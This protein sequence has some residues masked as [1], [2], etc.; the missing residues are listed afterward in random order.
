MHVKL[1]WEYFLIGIKQ[2]IVFLCRYVVHIDWLHGLSVGGANIPWF[3]SFWLVGLKGFIQA[4]FWKV[5]EYHSGKLRKMNI[6]CVFQYRIRIFIFFY[7][8]TFANMIRYIQIILRKKLFYINYQK[9]IDVLYFFSFIQFKCKEIREKL[10][11][12]DK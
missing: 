2:E 9:L 12:L 1:K 6:D 5:I 4:K 7:F 10:W 11:S 8:L 3:L